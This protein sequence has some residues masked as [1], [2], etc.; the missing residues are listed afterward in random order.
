MARP[1]LSAGHLRTKRISAW[2]NPAE[3][4]E[5]TRRT[6][7]AGLPAPEYLRQRAIRSTLHIE[8]PRRL[9]ASDFRELQRIGSNLN[10]IARK[11]NQGGRAPA[12]LN[13]RLRRLQELINKLLPEV[14]D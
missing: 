12:S 8:A 5:L 9:A 14:E 4:R 6:D 11:L 7:L 13:A 3:L 2:F 1:K 10:Q